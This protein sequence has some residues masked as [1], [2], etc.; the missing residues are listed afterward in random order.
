MPVGAT[1]S[2]GEISRLMLSVKSIIGDSMNLPSIIFDEVDTGVSGEIAARMGRMMQL[3]SH[4]IQIIT[5]THLPQVAA[6]GESHFKVYKADSE[7]STNTY[8]RR[9][10]DEDRVTEL[11]AMLGGSDAGETAAA[12]AR[13]LLEAAKSD[14]TNK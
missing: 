4:K 10:D 7:T 3:L 2:G 5:I 8:I 12:N 1:A 6:R 13:S 14:K 9:L 11:A